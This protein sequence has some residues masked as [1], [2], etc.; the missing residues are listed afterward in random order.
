MATVNLPLTVGLPVSDAMP[1]LAE[2]MQSLLAQTSDQFEI[3]A[4]V[5]GGS[6]GSAACL[7]TLRDTQFR[8]RL[9]LFEQP[10][11]G[12]TATLNRLL[13]ETRT[14]WLA[15]MD[16]DD[17]S[18][19]ARIERLL[20]AMHDDP[21]AGMIY[22]LAEYHPPGRCVGR[23]R[24]SQGTPAQLRSIVE[25]GYLLSICHSTVALNV[26]KARAVGG[27]RMDLHAED[28]DLWWRMALRHEIHLIPEVLVGFRQNAGSVS[29]RNLRSQELAGLYVQ[30][31]LLSELWRLPPRPFNE[32]A[33]LLARF[34]RP[35]AIAAKEALRRFNMQRA[36]GNPFRAC[37]ALVESGWKS[38]RYLFGRIRDEF[39]HGCL[40]NGIEPRLFHESKDLLWI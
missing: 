2:A 22:S 9:H 32:V 11:Q 1:W 26:E 17:I 7:R 39:R 13:E 38:P 25:S 23:F 3:L 10:H 35:S 21:E 20:Q 31:L 24:C 12:V 37:A 19:P 40:A 4:I 30:Y 33:P 5:D 8:N 27:Y 6:D 18:H 36:E 29:A 16:A 14:P 28:A 15:R 34:L